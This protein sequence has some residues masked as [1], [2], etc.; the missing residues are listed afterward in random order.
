MAIKANKKLLTP[1]AATFSSPC[2]CKRTLNPR[3]TPHMTK[4]AK[5]VPRQ[6]RLLFAKG[7]LI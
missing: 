4:E 1:Q 2:P 6:Y 3:L 5:A 7:F